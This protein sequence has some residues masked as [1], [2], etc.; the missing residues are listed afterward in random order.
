MTVKSSRRGVKTQKD[1]IVSTSCDVIAFPSIVK[2][3]PRE[4][5]PSERDRQVYLRAAGTPEPGPTGIGVHRDMGLSTGLSQIATVNS[6]P[7][8]PVATHQVNEAVAFESL[9]A[10]TTATALTRERWCG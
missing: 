5:G 2:A 4:A 1:W 8:D 6:G 10:C 7:G 3:H 9:S